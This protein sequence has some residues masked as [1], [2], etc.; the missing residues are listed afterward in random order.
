MAWEP[1]YITADELKAFVRVDDAT[2][3]AQVAFA[4]AAASR[5]VDYTCKRQ[6][7]QVASAEARVYVA[8][9]DGSVEIDD[10]MDDTDLAVVV[11]GNELDAAAYSLRPFNAAAT[12]RPWVRLAVIPESLARYGIEVTVTGL[13]GWADIPVAVK[14]ATLLQASRLLAR[15]DSPFGVA[16]SPAIG[17]ELRLLDRVDPDVA[18][19]LR[20][21]MRWSTVVA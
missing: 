13:F 3:D 7:G 18:V 6:F 4:I 2:D 9:S 12:G 15:R 11:D 21:Y 19:T 20:T 1:E 8:S 14:Q 5:A 10:L 17:S 16:G